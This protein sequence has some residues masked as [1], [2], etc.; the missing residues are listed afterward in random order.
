LNLP[1]VTATRSKTPPN[2][3]K[4]IAMLWGMGPP[5]L[6]QRE[7]SIAWYGRFPARSNRRGESVV[8]WDRQRQVTS[9]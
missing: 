1:P 9:R 8:S 4:P 5:F 7:D 3:S 6:S 2:T